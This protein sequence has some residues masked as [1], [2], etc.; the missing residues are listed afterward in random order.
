LVYGEYAMMKL[1]VFEWL[2]W[3]KGGQEDVLEVQDHACM[4]LHSQGYSSL[5]IYCT[6]TNDEC[7]AVK[8]VC[9]EEKTQPL[10]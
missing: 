7:S 9:S 5:R 3:F 4:F 10:A 6:M 2:R 1:S 8:G